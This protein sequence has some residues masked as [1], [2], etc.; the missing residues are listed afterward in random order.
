MSDERPQPSAS[1]P[2]P[3]SEQDGGGI[4]HIPPPDDDA[5]F[6]E[7]ARA[8]EIDEGRAAAILAY[9][10]FGCFVALV[11]FRD[12][13]FARRHGVQGLM[14]TFFEVL[15]GLFLIP[16]ISEYFWVTVV[17]ACLASAVTGIYYALQGREWK[18]PFVGEWFAERF[19]VDASLPRALRGD[20]DRSL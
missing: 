12:N 18:V 9:V 11:R 19:N 2:E 17:F 15:A 13:A 10:P 7:Q 1:N 8:E 6:D 16:R 20:D 4:G 14:L 3:E 5:V